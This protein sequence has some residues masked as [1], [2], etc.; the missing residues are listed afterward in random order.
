MSSFF[1]DVLGVLFF[2]VSL[3]G[4]EGPFIYGFRFKKGSTGFVSSGGTIVYGTQ[5]E[6]LISCNGTFFLFETVFIAQSKIFAFNC[7]FSLPF[8]Q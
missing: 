4:A 1:L 8:S 2:A 6:I 3:Q 5:S 7:Q